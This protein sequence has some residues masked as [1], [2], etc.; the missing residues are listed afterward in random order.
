MQQILDESFVLGE[1]GFVMLGISQ[2]RSLSG[3]LDPHSLA[4]AF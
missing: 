3:A 2:P 4:A 1:F